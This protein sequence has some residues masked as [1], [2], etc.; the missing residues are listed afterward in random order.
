MKAITSLLL[1]ALVATGC[2]PN[3]PEVRNSAARTLA[4]ILAAGAGEP[5]PGQLILP[6]RVR[7]DIAM[8]PRP[9]EDPS[10]NEGLWSTVDEQAI[11]AETRRLLE[12]NGL[13]MGM[14]SGSIPPG[15]EALMSKSTPI[16]DR[17]VPVQV[18]VPDGEKTDL[19]PVSQ[20]RSV[21]TLL[22]N[23]ESRIDGKDF[24]DAKGLIRLTASHHG[25]D[26]V[27]LKFT[28]EIHHGPVKHGYNAVPN[29]GPFSPQQ[30]VVQDGQEVESLRELAGSLNLQPGQIAVLGCRGKH[31]NS[32]GDFLFI[33]QEPNSDRLTQTV[34]LI[35][36]W[37]AD[38]AKGGQA[39][40]T[41]ASKLSE[42]IEPP[43]L[44][45]R[46]S[47]ANR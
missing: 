12:A 14:L 24:H 6:K 20:P 9:F 5:K 1:L 34:I 45:E 31:D 35:W 13:R 23:R 21:V 36:A 39:V 26:T 25:T 40:T 37:Q 38:S 28:P 18:E 2:T 41:E 4:G 44:G 17:V 22:L 15:F 32:L 10:V 47:P 16:K 7:L 43:P 8:I 11:S 46:D 30:F 33:Q 19:T 3:R 27:T 29:S 42:L